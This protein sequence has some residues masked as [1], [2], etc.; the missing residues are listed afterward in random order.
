[1]QEGFAKNALSYADRTYLL[2]AKDFAKK[3]IIPQTNSSGKVPMKVMQ[4]VK[5][6]LDVRDK[7]E[8]LGIKV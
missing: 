2:Q 8:S 7:L 3:A 4:M 6:V 5:A 1:M